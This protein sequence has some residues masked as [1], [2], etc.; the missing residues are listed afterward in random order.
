MNVQ[1]MKTNTQ[2]AVEMQS[3]IAD[4]MESYD[5]LMYAID[6]GVEYPDAVYDLEEMYQY[7]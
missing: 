4:G 3:M 6:E 7:R 5:C 2:L 1:E